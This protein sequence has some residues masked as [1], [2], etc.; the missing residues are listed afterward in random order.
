MSG[1]A[2]DEAALPRGLDGPRLVVLPDVAD[3]FPRGHPVKD[4]D[5]GERRPGPAE[6]SGTG[7]LD[8]LCRGPLP[9]LVERKVPFFPGLRAT[10]GTT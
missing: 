2:G 3:G 6:P 1:E 4:G 10:G 7:D 9:R 5:A 8:A